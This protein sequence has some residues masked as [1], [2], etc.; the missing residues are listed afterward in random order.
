MYRCIANTQNSL[1]LLMHFS[2]VYE[3]HFCIRSLVNKWSGR[4]NCSRSCTVCVQC[5]TEFSIAYLCKRL[6][7]YVYRCI[8]ISQSS[9]KLLM[10]FSMVYE[11]EF[12][13]ISLVNNWSSRENCSRSCTVC[14]Q[15]LTEF[16]INYKCKDTY[17]GKPTIACN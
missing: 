11:Y 16:S 2:R 3:Y 10:H 6:Y 1:K 15:C 8:A 14:V 12:C 13:I 7:S 9:L 17:N 4:E 5:Y